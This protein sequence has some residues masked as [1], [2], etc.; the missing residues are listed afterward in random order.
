MPTALYHVSDLP[1]IARFEPRPVNRTETG[2]PGDV[3]WAVD[4]DHLHNYLLPRDCPRVTFY[5]LPESAPADVE[6]L[7]CGASARH[8]VAIETDWLPEVLRCR[9]FVYELPAETFAPIDPGAGYHISA[10]AVA[11]KSVTPVEDVLAA[12]LA[13]DVEL[14]VMPS[15][16]RL[17]DTVI[18][19]TLQFSIIRMRNAAPPPEGVVVQRT[20]P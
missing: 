9:L 10:D 20:L 19:S 3:V 8:V 4:N 17:R 16:W 7:M 18:A 2:L 15:L 13:R 12:L 1:D 14:R 6:R 5:A 11:P